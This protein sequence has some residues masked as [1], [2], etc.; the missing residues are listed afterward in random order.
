ME[1]VWLCKLVFGL[2]DQVLNSTMIYCDDQSYVNL[3]ENL[4]FHDR[5][6]H[7]NIKHYILHDKFHRGEVVLHYISTNEKIVDIFG[8]AFVQDEKIAY[9][10]D[11]LGLVEMTSLLKK[12]EI[13]P[14]LGG[15]TDMLLI[16]GKSFSHL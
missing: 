14:K 13:T 9:L 16:Y 2:S 3:S 10:R 6:N 15:S 11:K 5:L 12:E 4:V 7:I 1:A 8:K